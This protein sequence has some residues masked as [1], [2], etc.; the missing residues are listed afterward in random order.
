MAV[1]ENTLEEEYEQKELHFLSQHLEKTCQV[2][3]WMFH[4][5]DMPENRS[6]SVW[7]LPFWFLA[8]TGSYET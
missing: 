6:K 1:M 7:T 5:G 3:R 8:V 2:K 4:F